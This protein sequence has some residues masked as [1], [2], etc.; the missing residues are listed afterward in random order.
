MKSL[1]QNI[2][3]SNM[4]KNSTQ[5]IFWKYNFQFRSNSLTSYFSVQICL[6]ILFYTCQNFRIFKWIFL[7]KRINYFT[8]C[9]FKIFE[10]DN[11]EF[12]FLF[13]ILSSWYF[14][15]VSW[16]LII[17][18]SEQGNAKYFQIID[19]YL[20]SQWFFFFSLMEKI[21]LLAVSKRYFF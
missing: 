10:S 14:K 16:N 7:S 12:S 1:I 6:R 4:T 21:F 17:F 13:Y 15:F 20:I 9:N 11:I 19:M 8:F 2:H 3:S 18:L 5:E